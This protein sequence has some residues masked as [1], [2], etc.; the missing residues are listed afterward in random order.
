MLVLNNEHAVN[1]EFLL[2]HVWENDKE[3][4][5]QTVILYIEYLK[6]KLNAVSSEVCIEESMDGYRL[7]RK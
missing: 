4:T 5:A 7:I 1:S 6:S 3:A 2:T